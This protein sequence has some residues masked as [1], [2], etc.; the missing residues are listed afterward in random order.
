VRIVVDAMGTDERPAPD[1]AGG[2][3]AA[4][5]FGDTIIFV[6]DSAKIEIELAKHNTSGL[7]LE[8]VHAEEEILMDDKPSVVMKAKAES[9]MHIGTTLVKNGEADAFMSCGNSGATHAISTLRTLR[10]IPGIKRPALAA[11]Y[12]FN[13][14][15]VVLLDVG[16]N[17]DSKVEFLQQFALM[18]HIYAKHTYG[19]ENPRVGT[20]SNGE[21]EGKGNQLTKEAQAAIRSLKNINYVGHIEPKEM[22]HGKADVIVMDGFVGNILIKTF[23]AGIA[24]FTDIIRQQMRADLISTAGAL[25]ARGAF[26]RIRS[27]IDP[28]GVGGGPLLGVNGVVIIG[29]GSSDA[30]SV[31][32]AILQARKAVEGHTVEEITKGLEQLK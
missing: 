16:A 3:I 5:E 25:L 19:I 26:K 13:G 4:R 11:I 2:V 20:L 17:A 12:P 23:E 18:G 21:E 10:R 7:S 15:P 9:S 31:R 30:F 8:V 28:R 29:H 22:S 6:G 1:I 24:Y 32:S 27:Q 14:K